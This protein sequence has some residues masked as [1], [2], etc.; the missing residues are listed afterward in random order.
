MNQKQKYNTE[1]QASNTSNLLKHFKPSRSQLISGAMM[2]TAGALAFAAAPSLFT[3]GTTINAGVMNANF[4]GIDARITALETVPA[5]QA[6][7][8]LGQWAD[9]GGQWA[10]AGYTKD[11]MGFV[12]LRGLI[13]RWTGTGANIFTLP[14]GY[15]P[16]AVLQFPARCG[17]DTMCYI[18]VNPNGNVDFGGVGSPAGSL[19][20]DGII[21]DLR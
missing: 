18:H 5:F 9:V 7:V 19:T 21:F 20:L 17:D 11:A 14:V 2:L 8:F 16:A 12:H 1:P 3:S 4:S 10:T 15:R 6:P 13:K